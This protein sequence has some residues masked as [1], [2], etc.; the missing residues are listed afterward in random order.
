MKRKKLFYGDT[1]HKRLVSAFL[2]VIISCLLLSGI[3]SYVAL[4]SVEKNKT[5]VEMISN[6]E[7]VT[8]NMDRLFLSMCQISEQMMQ[9]GNLGILLNSYLTTQNSYELYHIKKQICTDMVTVAF[10]SSDI[11]LLSYYNYNTQRNIFESFTFKEGYDFNQVPELIR[12]GDI[13]YN[14]FHPSFRKYQNDMVISLK[15]ESKFSENIS[16]LIYIEA[17]LD[18]LGYIQ[19]RQNDKNSKKMECII[20]QADKKGNI[21][22]SSDKD[23]FPVKK[24]FTLHSI[25]PDGKEKG[26]YGQYFAVAKTSKMGYTNLLLIRMSDYKRELYQWFDRSLIVFIVS[27]VLLYCMV[28]IIHRIIYG[29]LKIFGKEIDKLGEGSFELT[30]YDSGVLEFNQLFEQFNKM[31]RQIKKLITDVEIAEKEKNQLEVEKLIYQINPHFLMNTLNSVHWLAKSHNQPEISKFITN[32]NSILAYNL[33]KLDK[34]TTF[35]SEINM[36][37][38]YID[39]QKMRYDFDASIDVEE[40]PYLDQPTVRLLLQPLVENAIRYGLGDQG[41]IEIRI[42][43]HDVRNY[44]VLMIEDH[45]KGL[46]KDKLMQLQEPFRYNQDSKENSGIGLRYVRSMLETYYGDKAIMNINSEKGRGTKIT[47]LLPLNKEGS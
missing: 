31:K 11:N 20:L 38:N 24:D 26:V 46:S 18:L 34:D 1:I 21:C 2:L 15:R 37:Q 32:L 28:F 16:G 14:G 8:Q 47:L 45:G 10:P 7:Q 33:G 19:T 41:I 44:V 12:I 23:I 25:F 42:F 30:D 43:Y 39:L 6:L 4:I 9:Q 29:P 3:V 5:E 40:G 27:I 36:L 22:Y 35:R 13:S 17:K